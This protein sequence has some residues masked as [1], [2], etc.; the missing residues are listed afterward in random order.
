[1][2]NTLIYLLQEMSAL[3]CGNA[4]P[5]EICHII[6]IRW[7]GMVSPTAVAWKLANPRLGNIK[8]MWTLTYK[9]YG[10]NVPSPRVT[11]NAIAKINSITERVSRDIK[12]NIPHWAQE[13]IRTKV[14]I[15]M[16][17]DRPVITDM[18]RLFME[19][20]YI[21][22]KN[23]VVEDWVGPCIRCAA[24]TRMTSISPRIIQTKPGPPGSRPYVYALAFECCNGHRSAYDFSDCKSPWLAKHYTTKALGIET[25]EGIL[26]AW[27]G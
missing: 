11:L 12:D 24:R 14:S 6:L 1:M 18:P 10:K 2:L 20:R 8:T 17:G 22:D 27:C 16:R 21:V 7:C 4:L 5:T 9:I 19:E 15:Y 25:E 23:T 13:E 3:M 26:D